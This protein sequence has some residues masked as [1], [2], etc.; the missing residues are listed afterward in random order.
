VRLPVGQRAADAAEPA[1]S[2]VPL[3][4]VRDRRVDEDLDV[5]L[6]DVE[7]GRS[8]FSLAADDLAGPDGS[9]DDGALIQLEEGSGNALEHR[10]LQNPPGID[11]LAFE[12]RA[13][14]ALV[15]ERAGRTRDHAFAARHARRAAHGLIEIEGHVRGVA[16]PAA[17]DDHVLLD[18]VAAA[19]TAVA[20]DARLVVDRDAE[21]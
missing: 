9:L 11:L 2:A 21:R 16:A 10:E 17:S 20:Q 5:S 15:G 1:A 14:D 8:E 4:H 3:L 18:L 13:D 6:E 7:R 12:L 19:D